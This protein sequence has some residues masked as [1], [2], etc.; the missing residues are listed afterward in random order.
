MG[1]ENTCGTDYEECKEGQIKKTRITGITRYFDRKG[2]TD[3]QFEP[4]IRIKKGEERVVDKGG[5]DCGGN[6]REGRTTRIGRGW[7]ATDSRW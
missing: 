6:R 2:K 4:E 5:G 7:R 1:G 3:R